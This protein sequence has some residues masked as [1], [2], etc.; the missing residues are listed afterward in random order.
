MLFNDNDNAE[1][2]LGFSV[3]YKDVMVTYHF[4]STTKLHVAMRL[5]IINGFVDVFGILGIYALSKM[6][7]S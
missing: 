2:V 6:S 1:H 7:R 5:L 3:G 4:S